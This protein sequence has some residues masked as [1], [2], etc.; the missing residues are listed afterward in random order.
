M[1]A[2]SSKRKVQS[3]KEAFHSKLHTCNSSARYWRL[4]FEEPL[5]SFVL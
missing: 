5:L 2:R 3:A 4:A 1:K